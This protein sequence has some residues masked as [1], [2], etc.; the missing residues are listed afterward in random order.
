MDLY[1]RYFLQ[2]ILWLKDGFR[3]YYVQPPSMPHG[4][5][6]D[7]GLKRLKDRDHAIRWLES[8]IAYED[9]Y[10]WIHLRSFLGEHSMCYV[11]VYRYDNRRVL[12]ETAD[13]L[14]TNRYAIVERPNI[15]SSA[16]TVEQ[17]S[18]FAHILGKKPGDVYDW[19]KGNRWGRPLRAAGQGRVIQR[20][21]SPLRKAGQPPDSE[22]LEALW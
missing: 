9:F 4:D 6:V 16:A 14:R 2:H 7:V 11:P 15:L 10:S 20:V 3:D 5:M 12:F 21:R 13:M 22:S 1:S 19:G 8:C 17:G 18:I